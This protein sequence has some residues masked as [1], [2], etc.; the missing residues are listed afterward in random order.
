MDLRQKRPRIKLSLTEYL[1]LHK[2]VLERDRWRCQ[3]CGSAKDLQ[4]HHL[5][6]RSQLGDDTMQNLITLCIPCHGEWHKR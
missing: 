6:P 1:S 4:V 3:N 2:Q 5:Q